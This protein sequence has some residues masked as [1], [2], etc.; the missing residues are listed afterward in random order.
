MSSAEDTA[1]RTGPASLTVRQKY[2]KLKFLLEATSGD[3]SVHPPTL[4]H[5]S[6]QDRDQRIAK[7]VSFSNDVARSDPQQQVRELRAEF[8][9]KVAQLDKEDEEKTAKLFR[10][11]QMSVEER[12]VMMS[13]LHE[14]QTK[15]T[16]AA[17]CHNKQATKELVEA[18]ENE[19]LK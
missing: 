3:S 16:G 8:K 2:E 18:L 11:V 4:T 5:E 17:N 14:K 15:S 1:N 13:R 19:M 9:E 6:D 7:T 12:L 10:E